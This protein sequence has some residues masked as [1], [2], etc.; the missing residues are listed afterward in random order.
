MRHGELLCNSAVLLKLLLRGRREEVRDHGQLLVELAVAQDLDQLRRTRH[1]A[2]ILERFDGDLAGVEAGRKI[3]HVDG[4]DLLLEPIVGEAA[5]GN[6]AGHRRLAAFEPRL[7]NAVVSGARLLALLALAGGLVETRAV[8]TAEALLVAD[9]A[10]VRL[11]RMKSRTHF[12][13]L[14]SAASTFTRCETLRI[15]PRIAAVSFKT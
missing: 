9:R 2:L 13:C 4:E 1:Q 6:A 3:A 14:Y 8:T 15:M 11:Q 5:L 7:G 10:L 12:F